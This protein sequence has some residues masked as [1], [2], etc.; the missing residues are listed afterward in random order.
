MTTTAIRKKVHQYIDE[1]DVSVLE[2][3]WKMLEVFRKTNTS[4]LTQEQQSQVMETSAQY[5]A[6]KL[7]GYSLNEVRK[8]VKLKLEN[9]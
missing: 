6:G 5:K 8:K 3:V 2:V 4:H 9:N 1:A 7:K